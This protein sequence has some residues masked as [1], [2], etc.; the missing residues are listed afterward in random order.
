V[1]AIASLVAGRVDKGIGAAAAAA[2]PSSSVLEFGLH[3]S[4]AIL[5]FEKLKFYIG[6]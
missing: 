4:D 2:E 1:V 5:L 3:L 6:R